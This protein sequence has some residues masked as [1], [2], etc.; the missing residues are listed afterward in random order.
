LQ[1]GIENLKFVNQLSRADE[2]FAACGL[3]NCVKIKRSA[4]KAYEF[5]NL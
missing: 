3:K 1:F 2:K 5:K 4:L